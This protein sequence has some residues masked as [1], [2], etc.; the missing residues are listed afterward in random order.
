MEKLIEELTKDI[1]SAYEQGVTMEEAERLAAKFLH[2][3]IQLGAALKNADLDARMRKNGLKAVKAAVYLEEAKK[4]DKKPSDVML[5][6]LV[7]SNELVLGEQNGFDT[8]EVYRNELDNMLNVARD[9]HIFM[10][11]IA[12]G[13]FE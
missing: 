3:Q 10:R 2:A 4:G 13:R 12:K 6:S 5:G 8:A 1:K 9:A 11:G 7:D